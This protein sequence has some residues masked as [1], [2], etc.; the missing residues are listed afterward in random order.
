MLRDSIS[1]I[2]AETDIGTDRPFS[3]TSGALIFIRSVV[4][5]ILEPFGHNF[6]AIYVQI[7]YNSG[8]ILI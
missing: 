6:G 5:I 7:L 3:A 8:T 1:L 4:S 2:D